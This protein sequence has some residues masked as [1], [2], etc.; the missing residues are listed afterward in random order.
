MELR[1]LLREAAER[2]GADV[3]SL[4][5]WEKG[6][7]EPAIRFWPGIIAFLG[8]DPSP[9]PVTLGEHIRAERRRRGCSLALLARECGFDPGTL[10]LIEADNYQRIDLR[11]RASHEAI[12]RRYG[13]TGPSG[14][15]DRQ[16]ANP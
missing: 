1:L 6:K 8:C 9:L 3:F 16:T 15:D 4:I 2:I 14:A 12:Q 11:V 5:N 13:L 7:T 10:A